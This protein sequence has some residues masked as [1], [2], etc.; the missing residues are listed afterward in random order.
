MKQCTSWLVKSVYT[1]SS[2]LHQLCWVHLIAASGR[3][4]HACCLCAFADLFLLFHVKRSMRAVASC[5]CL[6]MLQGSVACSDP[7]KPQGP[8]PTAQHVW[9]LSC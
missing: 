1:R 8:V 5:T 9:I 6:C 4:M 7:S 2:R 3:H